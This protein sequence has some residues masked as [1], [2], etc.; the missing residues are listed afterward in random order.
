MA[1]IISFV[2]KNLTQPR[3]N[4]GAAIKRPR[5]WAGCIMNSRQG[6]LAGHHG[7]GGFDRGEIDQSGRRLTRRAF[8]VRQNRSPSGL[9]VFDANRGGVKHR[10]RSVGAATPEIFLFAQKKLALSAQLRLCVIKNDGLTK[11]RSHVEGH[12]DANF[13]T[14][15]PARVGDRTMLRD[16]GL[17]AAVGFGNSQGGR[18]RTSHGEGRQR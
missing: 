7:R 16:G 9:P 18:R 14:G 4:D 11:D 2:E 1:Q 8:G 6:A 12:L 3:G 15:F 17:R 10:K 5:T 13:E